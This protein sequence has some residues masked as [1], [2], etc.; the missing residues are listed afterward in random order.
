[1]KKDRFW[2]TI[3]K[4]SAEKQG[5]KIWVET[6][7][8]KGSDFKFTLPLSKDFKKSAPKSIFSTI[9]ETT[10]SSNNTANSSLPIHDDWKLRMN[11]LSLFTLKI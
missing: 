5:G 3:C 2:L 10:A 6:E 8:G 9:L 11:N 7:V 4:E 1:M